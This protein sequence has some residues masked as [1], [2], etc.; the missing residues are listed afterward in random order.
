MPVSLSRTCSTSPKITQVCILMYFE[1]RTSR[2]DR[3]GGGAPWKCWRQRTGVAEFKN[4]GISWTEA[5]K[6]AQSRVLRGASLMAPAPFGA[7]GQRS[8]SHQ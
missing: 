6:T 1:G 5:V 4:M 7:K 3:R 8:S 2:V